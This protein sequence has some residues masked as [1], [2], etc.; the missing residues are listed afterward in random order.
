MAKLIYSL[1]CVYICFEN[2]SILS[3]K[4][5]YIHFNFIKSY[6]HNFYIHFISSTILFYFNDYIFEN[7]KRRKV[8]TNLQLYITACFTCKCV[9]RDTFFYCSYTFMRYFKYRYSG[10]MQL[11]HRHGLTYN[12][13]E[14]QISVAVCDDKRK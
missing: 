12:S 7:V 10:Q 13:I 11:T 14:A 3:Q 1:L 5:I 4:K 2:K 9:L 8:E 6:A